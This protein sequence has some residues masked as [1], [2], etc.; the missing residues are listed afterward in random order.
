M[1]RLW[2]DGDRV[3]RVSCLGENGAGVQTL[4]IGV[5]F[6]IGPRGLKGD[7]IFFPPFPR[8]SRETRRGGYV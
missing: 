3:Q 1:G 6:H 7:P 5:K 2:G 4:C 8:F